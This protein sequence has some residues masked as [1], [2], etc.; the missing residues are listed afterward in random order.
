VGGG[1]I[2]D[3]LVRQIPSV[4]GMNLHLITALL[5]ELGRGNVL[6]GLDPGPQRC[7]VTLTTES[8]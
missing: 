2:R 5:D 8:D 4:C 1:V 3:T 6:A 7:C